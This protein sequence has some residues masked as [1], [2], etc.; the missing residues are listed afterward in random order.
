LTAGIASRRR[1]LNKLDWEYFVLRDPD[2]LLQAQP[3]EVAAADVAVRGTGT[4]QHEA[5]PDALLPIAVTKIGW[6]AEAVRAKDVSVS[7]Q[8]KVKSTCLAIT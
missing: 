5:F 8:R 3:E 6:V 7:F 1:W 2:L 4:S